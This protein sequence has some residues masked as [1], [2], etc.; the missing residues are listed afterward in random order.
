MHHEG[1]SP[2]PATEGF[3]AALAARLLHPIQLQILEAM[4][5]IGQPLSTSQLVQVFDEERTLP[6]VAYHV[7]RLTAMGALRPAGRRKVR[8]T[9]EKFYRLGLAESGRGS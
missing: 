1:G 3:W 6:I 2:Y 5:W 4:H 9:V 7:R 8:G